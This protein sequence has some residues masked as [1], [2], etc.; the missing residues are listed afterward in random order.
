V[1]ERRNRLKVL[2]EGLHNH[3]RTE[4]EHHSHR[5]MVEGRHNRLKMERVHRNHLKMVLVRHNHLKIQQLEQRHSRLKI[6]LPGLPFQQLLVSCLSD[7][8]TSGIPAFQP[9]LLLLL[10][11]AY[12]FVDPPKAF[13]ILIRNKELSLFDHIDEFAAFFGLLKDFVTGLLT[14]LKNGFT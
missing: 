1:V 2:A 11:E 5:L 9:L 4:E 3:L 12:S 7:C 14:H 10:P 13:Y 8:T 6:R